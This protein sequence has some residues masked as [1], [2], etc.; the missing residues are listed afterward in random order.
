MQWLSWV[1]ALLDATVKLWGE[2][3]AWKIALPPTFTSLSLKFLT[4]DMSSYHHQSSPLWKKVKIMMWKLFFSFGLFKEW[5]MKSV[6]RMPLFWSNRSIIFHGLKMYSQFLMFPNSLRGS[7]VHFV[8]SWTPVLD[9]P[10]LDFLV[11]IPYFE[12]TMPNI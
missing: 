2:R 8:W 10:V 9:P 12:R 6:L 4:P 3:L 1:Q 5:Q 7:S 11:C